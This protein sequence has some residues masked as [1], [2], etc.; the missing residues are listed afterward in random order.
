MA[1][2]SP[3]VRLRGEWQN[4]ET[5]Y[6]NQVAATLCRFLNVDYR[7]NNPQAGMPIARLFGYSN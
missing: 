2:I 6:Q 4:S 7:E 3:E 5:I 1:F